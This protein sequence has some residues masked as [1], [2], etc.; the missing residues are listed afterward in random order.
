MV[1]YLGR[2]VKPKDRQR[3]SLRWRIDR[4]SV[5]GF[6]CESSGGLPKQRMFGITRWC[7]RLQSQAVSVGLLAVRQPSC[8]LLPKKDDGSV[9]SRLPLEPVF[10][11]Q[12]DLVCRLLLEKKKIL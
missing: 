3:P 5:H 8:F 7:G 9:Y 1:S 6:E 4:Y 10:V 12:C 11:G 2:E